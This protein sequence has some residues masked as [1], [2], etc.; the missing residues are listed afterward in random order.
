MTHRA[1][2]SGLTAHGSRDAMSHYTLPEQAL[3]RAGSDGVREDLLCFILDAL[4]MIGVAKTLGVQLVDRFGSGWA[5]R[6]PSLR[7]D[8]LQPADR[9][10]V[11]GSI[12]E[13]RPDRIAAQFRRRNVFRR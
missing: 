1:P 5:R 13:N 8:N 12:R 7:G 10:A 11:A 4:Q 3:A 6:E 2:G 9:R